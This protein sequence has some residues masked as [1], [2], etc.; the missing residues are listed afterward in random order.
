ML[1]IE[2]TAPYKFIVFSELDSHLAS[3]MY[4]KIV[5]MDTILSTQL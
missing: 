3:G 5:I 2:K 4:V 1:T